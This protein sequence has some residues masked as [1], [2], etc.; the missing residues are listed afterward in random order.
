[1]ILPAGGILVALFVG[2]VWGFDKFRQALSNNG[3]LHNQALARTVFF[4]L[5]YVSPLLIL[6]VMLKGLHIF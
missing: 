6:I 5:R 4:L 2:W 3:Q 1:V